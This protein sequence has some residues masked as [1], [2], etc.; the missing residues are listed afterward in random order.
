MSYTDEGPDEC[1]EEGPDECPEEGPDECPE[2]G[3]DEGPEEGSDEGLKV[4]LHTI[5]TFALKN[6]KR[7]FWPNKCLEVH[8]KATTILITFL[9]YKTD[10]NLLSLQFL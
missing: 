7:N 6:M 3:S 4:I 1:P 10:S 5:R 8:R 2:E 9:P